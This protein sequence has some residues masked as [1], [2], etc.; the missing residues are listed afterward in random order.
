MNLE[1]PTVKQAW[2]WSTSRKTKST[3]LT[4]QTK[5][6]GHGNS[7]S[8][9][10][11]GTSSEMVRNL[12]SLIVNL[13]LLLGSINFIAVSL[14]G[15]QRGSRTT[16]HSF[17]SKDLNSRNSIGSSFSYSF[18]WYTLIHWLRTVLNLLLDCTM[19]LKM[20]Y[21][22]SSIYSRLEQQT[23]HSERTFH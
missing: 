10:Q 1:E 18:S 17:E 5:I 7:T 20:P 12:W 6:P 21:S 19:Y 22:F 9:F 23:I 4:T 2:S 3:E 14:G 13:T 8:I 15:I 16:V 11:I